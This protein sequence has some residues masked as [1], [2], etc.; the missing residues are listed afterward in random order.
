MMDERKQ[1]N[2]SLMDGERSFN[3]LKKTYEIEWNQYE[4]IRMQADE[5]SEIECTS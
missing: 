4:K 3:K 5:S 2:K 1:V